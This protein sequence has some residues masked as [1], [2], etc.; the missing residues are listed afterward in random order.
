VKPTLAVVVPH[1]RQTRYL[2]ECLCSLLQQGRVPDEVIVVDSSPEETADV[3]R[4]FRMRI[5][6]LSAPAAGVAAARNLGIRATECDLVS[7]LD[8]DNV[9]ADGMC[10]AHAAAFEAAAQTVLCHGAV[11]PIDAHGRPYAHASRLDSE[12]VPQSRQL[13]WLLERNWIATDSACVQ[14]RALLDVGGFCEQEGVR[15]DYDLWLRLAERGAFAYVERPLALY[16]RHATNLSND[17]EYMFRWEAGALRRVDP[18]RALQ[19][20]TEAFPE[21]RRQALVWAEFLLR[22][23][24]TQEAEAAL[25]RAADTWPGEPPF[26]FHLGN[27]A[28][29]AGELSRAE[30]CYRRVLDDS[31][32]DAAAWNN[33]GVVLATTGRDQAAREAFARASRLRPAY[34]DAAVNL[35]QPSALRLT[36]R[37]LRDQL[38]PLSPDAR[39]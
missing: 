20:I 24:D 37:R 13:G 4:P 34:Q 23:G 10:E 27:L 11:T 31:Q 17:R 5:Q 1:Y 19:A 29:D 35:A 30:P 2:A 22:R 12:R 28:L 33:L 21:R 36:R 6:Y 7:F 26:L 14:R 38:P 18:V 25:R 8:A 32:D 15:E 9:A 16:R 39:G 3:L